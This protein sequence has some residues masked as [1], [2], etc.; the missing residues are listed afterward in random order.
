MK[1]RV[2]GPVLLGLLVFGILVSGVSSVAARSH[3]SFE[4]ES[5]GV[6]VGSD[7]LSFSDESDPQSGIPTLC[8]KDL[9]MH[10]ESYGAAAAYP[11][12]NGQW[13][14]DPEAKQQCLQAHQ[15]VVAL[16]K[17]VCANYCKQNPT[18]ASRL[19]FPAKCT[20]PVLVGNWCSS[21]DPAF[22][23]CAC[24]KKYPDPGP[25]GKAIPNPSGPIE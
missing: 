17:V 20:D 15:E 4:V 10:S 12:P 1:L 11:L 3:A 16:A 19:I 14:C 23:V 8:P 21:V 2:L 22:G 7:Q 18:C 6:W 25:P 5:E 24:Y 9:P 13:Y